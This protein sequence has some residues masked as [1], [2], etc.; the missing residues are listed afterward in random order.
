[1]TGRRSHIRRRRRSRPPQHRPSTLSA[2]D[3]TEGQ[4]GTNRRERRVSNH[5][6]ELVTFVEVGHDN[7]LTFRDGPVDA[8][9]LALLTHGVYLVQRKLILGSHND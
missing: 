3:V 9:E 5:L 6:E 8:D 7:T 4:L 1:M 2:V